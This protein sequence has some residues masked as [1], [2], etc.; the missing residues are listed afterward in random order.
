MTDW[1]KYV[2]FKLLA[3]AA[4]NST[5]PYFSCHTYYV[6]TFVTVGGMASKMLC[7]HTHRSS[8]MVLDLA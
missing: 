7:V 5:Q 2:Y 1:I 8:F 4:H 6:Y 3:V